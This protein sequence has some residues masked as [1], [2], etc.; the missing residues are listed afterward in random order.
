MLNITCQ[1]FTRPLQASD[2]VRFDVYAHRIRRLLFRWRERQTGLPS[3]SGRIR[4]LNLIR[5]S[6]YDALASLRPA[7]SLLVPNVQCITLNKLNWD[8]LSQAQAF[9]GPRLVTITVQFPFPFEGEP[10]YPL[11]YLSN[12]F[13]ALAS[14]STR[15]TIPTLETLEMFAFYAE[16]AQTPAN[17]LSTC[18]SA[19]S[20][21]N[22]RVLDCREWILSKDALRH[23]ATLPHLEDL[24]VGRFP[25]DALH[26]HGEHRRNGVYFPALESLAFTTNNWLDCRTLMKIIRSPIL[27]LDIRHY[28]LDPVPQGQQ[29]WKLESFLIS[30]LSHPMKD[31][32]KGVHFVDF[33]SRPTRWNGGVLPPD[34]TLR[35]LLEFKMVSVHIEIDNANELDDGWL[36]NASRSWPALT[37]LIILSE[38]GNPRITLQGLIPLVQNCELLQ[39]LRISF[40]ARNTGWTLDPNVSNEMITSLMVERSRLSDSQEV[41][42]LLIAMFPNLT[43]VQ[44]DLEAGI[45]SGDLDGWTEVD[46][47]IKDRN[48]RLYGAP[49]PYRDSDEDQEMEEHEFGDED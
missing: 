47:H 17:T 2:L 14:H 42:N 43:E 15:H 28:D 18:I 7:S 5:R 16:D 12:L 4:D 49:N 9:I 3:L 31:T 23:L 39:E 27:S 26:D 34:V 19:L 22:L 10:L 48:E 11:E 21:N 45:E 38:K 20:F 44:S 30:L 24:L 35:A 46:A 36:G 41:F 29:L 33:G 40:D 8:I 6:A 32:L 25:P 13:I 37:E 1:V